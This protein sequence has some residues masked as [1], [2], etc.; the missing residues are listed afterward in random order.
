M[1]SRNRHYLNPPF[2]IP[3]SWVWIKLD[4]LAQ[5]KKGP[6][7]SSL[8]KAMF[9]P[10]SESA[11][12]VYEQKNAIQKDSTLGT[13]YISETHFERL[14]GFEV[15]P[16]DIIVSC[17]G[18]IGETYIMPQGIKR[19]IIN[20]ALMYIRPFLPSITPFYLIYF[21][22][23]IKGDSKMDGKGTAMKN[24]PPFEILKNYLFPL[25][26]LAEQTRI[27]QELNRWFALIDEIETNKQALQEAVKQTKSKILS[28]AISGKLVAQDPSDE[29]AI[30]LLRR[31]NPSF[32]PC[33]NSNY[34]NIPKSWCVV[35]LGDIGKWQAGGTPKRSI[36][37][38]YGG[39]IPWLKTGDLNDGFITDIPEHIT[40]AG[41]ENSAAKLNPKGSVL[42]AMY[43]ATIG[44]IGILTFP[45]TTNQACCACIKYPSLEMMYLYYFLLSHRDSFISQ[46]GGGAQPNISKEIII[47]TQMPLP[48]K[49]E[50]KRIVD[51]VSEIFSCIDEISVEL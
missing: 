47:N 49:N 51:K 35:R 14:K 10:D 7:G 4:E 20:Q 17:A 42:V 2:K 29:P 22:S 41:L 12:K 37:D 28:L 39:D 34:E 3:N 19:G 33:D 48:P 18:T 32:Q 23:I 46:G 8:T 45:A 11:F 30:D 27:I 13:Y 15:L 9:V 44:R 6:F 40:Q 16:N 26:P 38:Y 36:K 25:P 43:G 1:A 5:Y 50:Q 31:I 21:D 24:I